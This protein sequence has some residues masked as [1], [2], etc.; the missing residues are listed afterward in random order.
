M[1]KLIATDLDGTLF[2]PK[3]RLFV[4][5]HANK[6]LLR[7][8]LADGGKVL[9]VSGR[10][11]GVFKRVE[12]MLQHPI[13][14]FGCNGAYFYDDSGVHDTM[15]L[16]PKSVLDFY[17]FFRNSYSIAAWFIFD[18]TPV[19]HLA[20]HDLDSFVR[21]SIILG[22]LAGGAYREKIVFGEDKLIEKIAS[23]RNFKLMM[24]FGLGGVARNKAREV[25]L[26]VQ[27]RFGDEFSIVVSENAIEVT[28]K[29]VSKG[30][31]LRAYCQ[32]ENIAPEEVI[33]CGDSG[34]DIT[35]FEQFPHSFAMSHSAA[36][37]QH[38]ANHVIDIVADLRPYLLDSH[39]LEKDTIKAF[40]DGK[41]LE[42][43]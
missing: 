17:A 40:P 29:N 35:M 37:F 3:R 41:G 10:S 19:L 32:R 20:F 8:F 22:N 39:R 11:I 23:P 6:K 33:V 2:Y 4:M 43:D 5:P 26:A 31:A 27:A 18:D 38:R 34:N 30:N 9:M 12:K 25:S 15:P 14:L 1:I 21:N 24:V 7:E 13:G 42:K 16:D 28:A 36:N